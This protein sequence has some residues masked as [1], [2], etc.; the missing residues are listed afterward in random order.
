MKNIQAEWIR[1]LLAVRDPVRQ[2]AYSAS[3]TMVMHFAAM[4]RRVSHFNSIAAWTALM[5]AIIPR[6]KIKRT[7]GKDADEKLRPRSVIQR[8]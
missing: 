4:P 5:L 2:T 1:M 3:S 8:Q 7:P 6:K